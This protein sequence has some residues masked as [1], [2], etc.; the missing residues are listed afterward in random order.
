MLIELL[1]KEN[2]RLLI[3]GLFICYF[4]L[5]IGNLV[6]M[7]SLFGFTINIEEAYPE[8]FDYNS[9]IVVTLLSSVNGVASY[10]FPALCCAILLM[11]TTSKKNI[12]SWLLIGISFVTE[13]IL[14]SATSL[15]GVFIILVYVLCIYEK[16]I[17]RF[18]KGSLIIGTTLVI[19]LGVTFFNIQKLF[20]FIIVDILHKDMTMTGRTEVW[21]IGYKGFFSSPVWGC[22]ISASTIDN[23]FI[24]L[25]YMGGLIGTFFF[26]LFMIY[27]YRCICHFRA[28]G[29]EKFFA[30]VIAV[31]LLMFM[32]EAWPQ[33]IGLYVVLALSAN[34]GRIK[35]KLSNLN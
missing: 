9:E 30:V 31:V 7:I 5:L 32:S 25:L 33:F 16:K 4:I 8:V 17:Q 2:I 35:C 12:W 18:V 13:L 14:W 26:T 15:T 24:Q 22:G 29:I 28:K 1:I 11:F 34:S 19:S 10:I 27:N 3:Q 23:G 6:Y 20:S 21:K